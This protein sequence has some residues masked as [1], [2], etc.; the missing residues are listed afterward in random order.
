MSRLSLRCQKQARLGAESTQHSSLIAFG[1]FTGIRSVLACGRGSCRGLGAIF[2]KRLNAARGA[3]YWLNHV[4]IADEQ[5]ECEPTQLISRSVEASVVSAVFPKTIRH[6]NSKNSDHE[7][8]EAESPE[9]QREEG[10]GD[11]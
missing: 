6:E 4:A 8:K 2:A 3:Q 1:R 9:G 7:R 5:I 11:N 10:S